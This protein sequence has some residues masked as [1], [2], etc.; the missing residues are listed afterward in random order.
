MH[1]ELAI[2]RSFERIQ[3]VSR[4]PAQIHTQKKYEDIESM[5]MWTST[6]FEKNGFCLQNSLIMIRSPYK[7]ACVSKIPFVCFK[8]LFT[9]TT[10]GHSHY[11]ITLQI[12][13]FPLNS[14]CVDPCC[15][16]QNTNSGHPKHFRPHACFAERPGGCKSSGDPMFSLTLPGFGT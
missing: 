1:V 9:P 15:R 7:S 12:Y 16:L 13:I 14:I 11:S 8:H 6:H 10:L 4:E 3:D 5:Q 2:S